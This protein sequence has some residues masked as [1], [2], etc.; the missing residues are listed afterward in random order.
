MVYVINDDD[1]AFVLWVNGSNSYGVEAARV[2]VR[3][4]AE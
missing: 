4:D 3:R 2:S 1:E